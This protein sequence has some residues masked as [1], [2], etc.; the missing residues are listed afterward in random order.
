MFKF[1]GVAFSTPLTAGL[2]VA[3]QK[4]NKP[5]ITVSPQ[6]TILGKKKKFY[7]EAHF[8]SSI[9]NDH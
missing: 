3:L 9:E 2:R 7:T 6:S 8:H 5:I 4:D 1:S